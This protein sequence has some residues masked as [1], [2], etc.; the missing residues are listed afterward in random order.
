MS[1]DLCRGF[2]KGWFPKGWFWQVFPCTDISSKQPFSATLPWQKKGMIFDFP[3]PQ[4][5][6][7]PEQGHIL[8]NR[9]FTKPPFDKTTL[10]Q[11]HLFF[12]SINSWGPLS[13][14]PFSLLLAPSFPIQAVSPLLPLFPSSPPP[15]SP[16]SYPCWRGSYGMFSPPPSFPPGFAALRFEQSPRQTNQAMAASHACSRDWVLYA[17]KTPT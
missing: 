2:A 13:S 9:A 12:L 6:K 1:S 3:G 11:N 10:W 14:H 17:Q 7:F 5:R 16:F 4:S 15:L 8:Q